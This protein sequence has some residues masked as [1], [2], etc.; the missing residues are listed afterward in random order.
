[1]QEANHRTTRQGLIALLASLLIGGGF[2]GLFGRFG[3]CSSGACTLTA[4]CK[5]GA[6]Y[7]VVLGLMSP[8]PFL[9][10]KI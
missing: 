6:V 7:G 8:H 5:R 10:P 1:V 3:Q 2:G 9:F 4:N